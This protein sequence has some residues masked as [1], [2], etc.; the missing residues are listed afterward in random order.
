MIG[1]SRIEPFRVIADGAS[2]IIHQF[3]RS[4]LFHTRKSTLEALRVVLIY[5]LAWLRLVL[6]RDF[7][8]QW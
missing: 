1:T 5:Q 6:Q 2:D 3:H 4:H 8:N 7:S